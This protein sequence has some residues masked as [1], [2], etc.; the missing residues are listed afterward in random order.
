MATAA[1]TNSVATESASTATPKPTRTELGFSNP[2]S[3]ESAWGGEGREK[4]PE[5]S[6][7][8]CKSGSLKRR[9]K[10]HFPISS[11][12]SNKMIKARD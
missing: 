11:G 6:P 7:I 2:E 12:S 8:N 5:D 10:V 9:E 4:I 3:E 1:V